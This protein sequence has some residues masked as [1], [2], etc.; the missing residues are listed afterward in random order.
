M[1]DTCSQQ[2]SWDSVEYHWTICYRMSGLLQ[3]CHTQGRHGY[4]S[5]GQRQRKSR[6]GII[7]GSAE[8]N[9]STQYECYKILFSLC[10]RSQPLKCFNIVLQTCAVA[11]YAAKKILEINDTLLSLF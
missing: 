6:V 2:E 9:I 5:A 1:V 8:Q 4:L 11:E 3:A 7:E 10:Y